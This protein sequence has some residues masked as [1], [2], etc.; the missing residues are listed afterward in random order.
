MPA[1]KTSSLSLAIAEIERNAEAVRQR[2]IDLEPEFDFVDQ[3]S[4]RFPELYRYSGYHLEHSK[5]VTASL[6]M[7]GH[8]SVADVLRFCGERGYHQTGD[9]RDVRGWREYQLGTDTQTTL[10][11]LFHFAENDGEGPAGTCRRVQ[12]GTRTETVPVYEVVC[13]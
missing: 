7:T 10:E 9:A 1:T 3:L 5:V 8:E 2:A 12:V 11:L 4:V 13:Q 6:W